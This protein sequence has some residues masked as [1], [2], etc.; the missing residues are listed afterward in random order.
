MKGLVFHKSY[1]PCNML[2][3]F[4]LCGWMVTFVTLFLLMNSLKKC[5]EL[6]KGQVSLLN[7]YEHGHRIAS[8]IS[9]EGI[10]QVLEN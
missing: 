6:L 10:Y 4:F 2:F 3:F 9:L 8:R 7:G 5:N 1:I